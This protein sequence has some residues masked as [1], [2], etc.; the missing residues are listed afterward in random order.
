MLHVA[1]TMIFLGVGMFS[2]AV[3]AAML[4]DHAAAIGQALGMRETSL[5]TLPR[6]VS[7]VRVV[8]S[9]R[10]APMSPVPLRAVA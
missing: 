7:R 6:N 1:V 9:P 2:L 10:L 4:I 5:T 3:I 8:R